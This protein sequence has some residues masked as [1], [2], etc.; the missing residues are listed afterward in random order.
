VTFLFT[1]LAE[2]PIANVPRVP[3]AESDQIVAALE[4]TRTPVWYVVFYDEGHGVRKKP[5]ADFAFYTTVQ[6]VQDFLLE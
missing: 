6:F 1:S 2:F 4:K 5:N 3:K